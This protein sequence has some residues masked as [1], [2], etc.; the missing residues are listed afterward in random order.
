MPATYPDRA[1]RLTRRV[2]QTKSAFSMPM[3][4]TPAADPMIRME[5]PVPA[6]YAMSCHS[7][8]SCGKLVMSYMPIVAATSGTL[9]MTADAR[10]MSAAISSWLGTWSLSHMASSF[11][12]PD[13]SSA[14]MDMRMPRK[15]KMPWVSIFV[16]ALGTRSSSRSG[17]PWCSASVSSQMLPR[18]NSMP[19]YGGK[20]VVALKTGTKIRLARPTKKT[21]MPFGAMRESPA[22]SGASFLPCSSGMLVMSASGT[23]KLTA[24]G[25]TRS[26]MVAMVE[27]WPL[28]HSI[29][30]V[31]SPMGV[32][33]PPA[34]AAMT[35]TAPSSLRRSGSLTSLRSRE[36][37]TMVDVRLS[38]TADKQKVRM[39]TNHTRVVM[40]SVSMASV[41][42]LKPWW[43][44]TTSTMVIAPKRKK[45][46]PETSDTCSA[47]CSM[48]TSGLAYEMVWMVH[49]D[50]AM[51]KPM[52]DLLSA[53]FSSKMMPA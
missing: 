8:S 53:T 9:S 39:P 18:P 22:L 45:M 33:A 47:S 35:T 10:P 27:I 17:L 5:P 49:K 46:M 31:T 25:R 41:M 48:G 23:A 16:R 2:Y 4:A 19:R 51:T 34:L 44:S 28:I 7:S 13:E 50:T 15:K 40:S 12:I 32:H 21:R 24:D 11:R 42:I 30:V 20:P 43:A 52:A 26:F 36:T 29:V 14:A 6:Q 3:K 1:Q 38:S 37:I